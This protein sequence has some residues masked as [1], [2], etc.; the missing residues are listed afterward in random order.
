MYNYLLRRPTA[1]DDKYSRGVVGFITGSDEFVG[2]AILGVT[3]AIRTGAGMVRYLGSDSVFKYVVE[4]R[5]EV[6]KVPGRVQSWVVG[7]GVASSATNQ[8][9]A[10]QEIFQ[11][12]T[13]E[14]LIVDAGALD[15]I[16]QNF[17]RAKF[18]ILTPHEGEARRLL[19]RLGVSGVDQLSRNLL[20]TQINQITGCTV[21]LKGNR[22]L[23]ATTH[24]LI[25]LP[26]SPTELASAGTGDVLAG[27][28]GAL[29]AINHDELVAGKIQVK[30][31]I[32][33]AVLVHGLAAEK[34]SANGPLAALD[35]AN[36]VSE[37]IV[38]IREESA[39]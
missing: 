13:N 37:A 32:G 23:I 5:P 29:G 21:L 25:E 14:V 2:A 28:L 20:A 19:E 15:L 12:G 33:A 35:L 26:A 36:A 6:I 8:L 24:E 3:A 34:A 16:G 10:I 31:L 4:A 1:S 9:N 30:D 38:Q 7:S 17:N 39:E 18:T 11:A 22:S 27:I